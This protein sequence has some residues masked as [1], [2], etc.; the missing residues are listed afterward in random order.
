[1]K[2]LGLIGLA[3]GLLTLE[4]ALARLFQ[5]EV[6]RPDPV[7]PLVIILALRPGALGAVTCF[8][9]GLVADSFGGTPL[10][11]LALVYLLIW[12]L[13]RTA[14]AY[15]LPDRRVVQYGLLFVM[16]ILFYLA[17]MGLLAGVLIGGSSVRDPVVNLAL[18]VLPLTLANLL[19]AG[20]IWALAR[21]IL[22]AQRQ[23]GLFAPR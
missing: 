22:G 12:G 1:M 23:V 21:R 14:S 7:L 2:H 3:L 8:G 19:L 11:M 17:L 16:S 10:G 18:W 13:V 5:L 20:P 9:L 4:G 15:L 6:L